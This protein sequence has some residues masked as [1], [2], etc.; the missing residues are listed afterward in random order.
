MRDPKEAKALYNKDG[1]SRVVYT[2]EEEK[3]AREAGF[4]EPYS[5]QEYPKS[6]HKDGDRKA[7]E[8]VVADADEEEAARAEGF[9]T[10]HEAEHGKTE[11]KKIKK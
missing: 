7:E 2:E 1:Q 10:I 9:S 3:K 8:R 4:T 6:L 11:K 5:H